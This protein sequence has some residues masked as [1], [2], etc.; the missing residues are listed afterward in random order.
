MPATKTSPRAPGHAAGN[1]AHEI[2]TAVGYAETIRLRRA[3]EALV[4]MRQAH[5]VLLGEV[6]TGG[7]AARRRAADGY[8]ELAAAT[9]ALLLALGDAG[10]LA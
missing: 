3:A 10:F 5:E 7:R 2:C 4:L 1:I 8:D 9:D 6:A